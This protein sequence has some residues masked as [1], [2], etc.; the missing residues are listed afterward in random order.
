MF[1]LILYGIL[2]GVGGTYLVTKTDLKVAWYDWILMVLAALFLYL[3]VHDFFASFR[4]LSPEASWVLLFGFGVPG[5][6]FGGI[7]A[8]RLFR[9]IQNKGEAGVADA[10]PASAAE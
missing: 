4:E 10:K 7:V 5:L 8:F 2:L 3:G 6:I 9:Q 1:W